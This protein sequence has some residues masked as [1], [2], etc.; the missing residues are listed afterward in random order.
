M[1]VYISDC[2]KEK[3]DINPGVGGGIFSG[4][5]GVVGSGCSRDRGE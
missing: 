4:W 5:V 3:V 2:D 1:L